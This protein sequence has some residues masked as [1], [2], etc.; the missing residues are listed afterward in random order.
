MAD[1]A[2][3]ILIFVSLG[4]GVLL[5]RY[6]KYRRSSTESADSLSSEYFVGLNY[7]LNEQTDE[8]IESF[9][10][11]L[12]VNG[13][14]VE[15]FVVLGRLFRQRGQLDKAIQAHQDILARPSL[16]REQMLDVQLELAKDYVTAGLF[17]RAEALLEDIVRQSWR[18]WRES[19]NTLLFV[20]ET[21][22]DWKKCV[23]L[24]GR[25]KGQASDD[26]S[27]RLSHYYCELAEMAIDHSDVL[28]ARKY[29]KLAGHGHRS[30]VRVSLLLGRLE[31]AAGNFR[32]AIRALEKIAEQDKRYISESIPQLEES[33]SHIRSARGLTS[34]LGRCLRDAP[35]SA[36]IMA[37]ARLVALQQGDK[38]AGRFVAEQIVK[39]PS[40]KGLN[41][42][43]DLHLQM[44]E[45]RAKQ[46]LAMLRGLTGRLENS[47]P[48]HRCEQCGFEGKELHWS[49][50]KC[51][52]WGTIK[53]IMGL[54]GE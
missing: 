14:T 16:T 48:V 5:G 50:P 31:M 53:P 27:F 34:Y 10:R 35:S 28:G 39:R 18:G 41:A 26:Y 3:L 44:A 11:A 2:L 6:E 23:L 25:L 21:E 54:E 17:D 13:D 22:K 51:H 20:Y 15:T 38:E 4:V 47:K 45:G 19:F 40:L 36:V 52:E 42:L 12:E 43:I 49:C 46:N 37:S 30:N 1:V 9:I 24:V 7:L 8:A 33:Y 29:L 32:D